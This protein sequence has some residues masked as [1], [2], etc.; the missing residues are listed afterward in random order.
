MNDGHL[1]R[2]G[3]FALR[4]DEN[5]LHRD[6]KAV[7][8]TP[9]M[10]DMLL[11]LVKKHGQ[12]VDKDTLL[13]EV[14]PDS[15]VEEG[16]ITF[17]IRQLRKILDDDAQSPTYIETVPRRG[18]RFIAEV[19]EVKPD[20]ISE[21]GSSPSEI[22]AFEKT[23]HTFRRFLF[24]AL[25][26]FLL[27]IG[28]GGVTVW[29]FQN[30][31][32]ESVPI[33]SAPF[34]SEKLSTDGH[35][36]HAV[37]SPDG[38]N[39]VYT[40]RTSGKQ[41]IWLRQLETSNNI[42]IVPP[43]DYFY[44]GL[45]ISPDG[46][47]V[48]FARGSQTVP[49]IDIFRM[50]I[51][52]GVPQKIIDQT[53]GW[54]SISANG[55]KISFV[56]CPYS[57]DEYCS[58]YVADTLDGKNEKKIVSRPRPIRI[59]DNKISPDGRTVAFGVGQSRTASNEFSLMGVDIESRSERE[60]TTQK[61]F[62]INYIAWL[63]DSSGLLLTA[64]KVADR[65]NSIW[66]V[67]ASTGETSILTAD[68]EAYSRL[69][70]DAKGSMLISTQVEPDFHLN[71]YQTANPD[72]PP[73]VLSNAQSVTF[74]GNGKLVFSSGMTG[75]AEIW[76]INPDGSDRRQ[77]TNNRADDVAP[78]VSPN[79]SFIF[80]DSNRTG[81]IQVWRMNPDG[82]DQKQ[83]TTQEGGFP[84]RVSPDGQWLYYRSG[85]HNSL[86]RVAIES[87][88]EE[89]VLNEMGRNLV[90]S[91]DTTQVAF[92]ERKNQEIIITVYSLADRRPVKTFSIVQPATSL[93]HLTWSDKGDY[94]G[95]VLT[96]D[97]SENARLFIQM[98][99]GE[100]ARQIA[101]LSGDTIAELS[102]LALSPDGKTFAVVKGNWKHDA[103]LIRGLK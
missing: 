69:S 92:S 56:R 33:L 65:N 96:D 99:N 7:P 45:A 63:P 76:S 93:Y 77:L 9:K 70:L 55:E 32:A 52:G 48:Y 53:Q 60:L 98:L 91:P 101:D 34:S 50:P 51:V 37:I 17:N 39:L 24:P 10:F 87:G 95:Y 71:V 30:T 68:S 19:V 66:H 73:R 29:Y 1:Y 18:Y 102:A 78:I 20:P 88:Q 5:V 28:V 72:A 49:Q 6:G 80:F 38:K 100:P 67:S 86:R 97:K 90:V 79:N 35:V 85:L 64:R 103:V 74:T 54:I 14:W 36:F 42:Q 26:V 81:E 46:E 11:V 43:S 57:D 40:H 4:T 75:D 16:N 27:L 59:G 15:F 44:G 21:N 8:L 83:V 22:Q 62:N 58:L 31:S 2:F 47:V 41:S 89:L 13:N 23:P 12:I 3:A 61:F 84:L 94:L 25:A 82:T